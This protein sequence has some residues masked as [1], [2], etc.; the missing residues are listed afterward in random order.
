MINNS[1]EKEIYIGSPTREINIIMHGFDSSMNSTSVSLLFE[2][3]K[4]QQSNVIKFSFRGHG[5]SVGKLE[6]TTLE[7]Q[8]EDLTNVI[9]FLKEKG[10]EKFNLF[11]SS[12]SGQVSL[13]VA[14]VQDCVDKVFLK[15]PLID[16][17]SH[18][19][20]LLG[21]QKL[22]QIY[23]TDL[24][25]YER[26]NGE[27]INFKAK[28]IES[29]RKNRFDKLKKVFQKKIILVHGVEDKIVPVG[30]VQE[31]INILPKENVMLLKNSG[32][33]IQGPELELLIEFYLKFLN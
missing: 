21:D 24:Y 11:G 9:N 26:Y 8:I 12:F 17:Y 6:D 25:V 3:L 16:G 30:H 2:R 13:F 31:L 19:K 15:C 32:H 14:E 28:F 10:Y 5:S 27:K 29:F 18:F 22:D 7:S 4:L 1:L 33:R 20:N 23:K